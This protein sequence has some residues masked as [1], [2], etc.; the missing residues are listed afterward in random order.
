M[1][2]RIVNYN[3]RA[4]ACMASSELKD[5]LRRAAGEHRADLPFRGV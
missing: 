2:K 5:S 1:S 3:V 4:M